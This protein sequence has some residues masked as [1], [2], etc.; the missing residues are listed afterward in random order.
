MPKPFP[1][2]EELITKA[3]HFGP[4]PSTYFIERCETCG[5]G[6]IGQV[7]V[8][9]TNENRI[10][11]VPADVCRNPEGACSVERRKLDMEAVCARGEY[12][13]TWFVTERWKARRARLI[14]KPPDQLTEE[15]LA[16]DDFDEL[17]PN[18]VLARL[19]IVY[20]AQ[21]KKLQAFH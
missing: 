10:I 7:G 4:Q 13:L 12:L 16:E 21:W 18:R 17:L 15:D 5:W 2:D 20:R 3:P 6:M 1:T 14:Q 9:E 11:Q 8:S 19:A